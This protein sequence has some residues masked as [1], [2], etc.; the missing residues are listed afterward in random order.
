M[1]KSEENVSCHSPITKTR[2]VICFLISFTFKP[3]RNI[4]FHFN[5][6]LA[7]AIIESRSLDCILP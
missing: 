2:E 7:L 4:G 1:V 5:T 6:A 3:T